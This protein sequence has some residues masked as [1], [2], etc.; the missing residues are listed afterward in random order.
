ML[1]PFLLVYLAASGR[2][3][4]MEKVAKCF[5]CFLAFFLD[6]KIMECLFCAV[7]PSSWFVN[8][9]VAADVL[10]VVCFVVLVSFFLKDLRTSLSRF[11][12][13]V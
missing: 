9:G 4:A 1:F 12:E 6:T 10:V 13:N 5:A 11:K 2:G 3:T 7:F 8:S